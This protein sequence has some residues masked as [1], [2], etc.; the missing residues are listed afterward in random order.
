MKPPPFNWWILCCCTC[1][2]TLVSFPFLMSFWCWYVLF[3]IFCHVSLI[4]Q[5]LQSLQSNLDVRFFCYVLGIVCFILFVWMS[6]CNYTTFRKLVD[7]IQLLQ[8]SLF[9]NE[10]HSHFERSNGKKT[11]AE[12]SNVR[13]GMTCS[14]F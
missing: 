6:H 5:L 9:R 7:R 14:M 8:R 11:S 10:I 3:S 1:L 12:F 2:M 4:Y 13:R